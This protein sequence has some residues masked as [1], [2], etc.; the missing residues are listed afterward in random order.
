ML[1]VERAGKLQKI[2]KVD[3]LLVH[4]HKEKAV[5]FAALEVQ[6]V[7]ISGKTIRPAFDRYVETGLLGD[8]GK[9]RTDFRSSAQKRLMP[10]LALKVPIF[11]RWGKKFFVAVDGTFFSELPTIKKQKP[12]SGE[13]TWLA[14][15]IE[16][17]KEGQYKMMPP[18]VVHTLWD[19]V[20][21]ALREGIAP[22]K[23]ELM[24]QL[25]KDIYKFRSFLT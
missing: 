25:S 17:Q 20:E 24:E 14:Y 13:V 2:G 19:D 12:G 1:E 7:Y 23:S 10:Q 3:Y 16:R 5:D 21:H 8:D 18:S 4:T 15:D 11:R 9:R 6:A 22:E